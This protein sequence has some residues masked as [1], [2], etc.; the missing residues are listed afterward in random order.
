MY[1][2]GYEPVS[3]DLSRLMSSQMEFYRHVYRDSMMW[4]GVRSLKDKIV[5][6]YCEQ[7]MG[8][9]IQFARYFKYLKQLGCLVVLHCPEPLHKLLTLCV[10]GVDGVFDREIEELPEHDFH[11]LSMSLPFVL[12]K[13]ETPTNAYIDFPQKEELPEGLKIGIAWEGNPDHTNNAERSCPLALFKPLAAH[14]KLYMLQQGINEPELAANCEDLLLYGMELKD[15]TDT[16]RLVNSMDLVVSVDTAAVHLAGAMG[17][18]TIALLSNPCDYRWRVRNWYS[19][20]QGLQQK[21]PGNWEE[22]FERVLSIVTT[23]PA[24]PT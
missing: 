22:V 11:I 9:I 4:N 3:E 10:E 17:K 16:A 23:P 14:A 8:D 7:G 24:L 2:R 18:K 13:L 19:S 15:F 12:N 5:I 21:E 6:V 1:P 20:V